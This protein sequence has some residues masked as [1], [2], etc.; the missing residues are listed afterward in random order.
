MIYTCFNFL[1][2]LE[3]GKEQSRQAESLPS[4]AYALAS[5]LVL[6]EGK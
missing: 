1:L 6:Q 3:L 2:N 5:T 4:E